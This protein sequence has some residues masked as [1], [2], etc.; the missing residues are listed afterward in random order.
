M[1]QII[2]DP[3]S[4]NFCLVTPKGK[5]TATAP[6]TSDPHQRAARA[7][8][9]YPDLTSRLWHAAELATAGHIHPIDTP[10]YNALAQ[11]QSETDPAKIYTIRQFKPEPELA[12]PA[13]VE[14]WQF[15]C[16]CPDYVSGRAKAR[17]QTVCKHILAVMIQSWQDTSP[18]PPAAAPLAEAKPPAKLPRDMTPEERE[19]MHI[20]ESIER[21]RNLSNGSNRWRTYREIAAANGQSHLMPEQSGRYTR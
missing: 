3:A 19:R 18:P 20:E 8:I 12:A 14:K 7:S 1:Y 17:Y 11:V 10:D 13:T 15:S 16:N 2:T 4:G 9:K 6:A 21:Q 5:T